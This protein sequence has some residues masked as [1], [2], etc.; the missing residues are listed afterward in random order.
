M[1]YCMDWRGVN[2]DWNR[3]RA[4][5]VTAE[6]G[7]LSAAAR[8]LRMTQPTLGRQVAA[9]EQELGVTLFERVGRGLTLTES[10]LHLVE[11]V[12]AM[13]EAAS[14][15]S[16]S[17]SG[18]AQSVQGQVAIT[19]PELYSSWLLPRVLER[20]RQEAPGITVDLVAT[21]AVRDL[22]RREADIAIRNARPDQPDLIARQ[23]AEDCGS[24][25]ASPAYLDGLGPMRDLSDLAR[26]D[27]IGFDH[28]AQ[29]RTMLNAIGI[30]V[31]EA[32]FPLICESHLVHWQMAREG[33]GIGAG[34]VGMG[35]ADPMVR[36]VFPDRPDFRYP[37]WLVAH[38]ELLTSRRVRLV[39]DVLAEMLPALLR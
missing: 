30:P 19:A 22:K 31:T 25:Y 8:A 37:V 39:Y 26:A 29:Y 21:N 32:N 24:L 36:R 27:F 9:L 16:L 35:E 7:S 17:A 33:L 5:L 23:V 3:A 11:H 34:P 1:H 12:R 13:G 2:F 20:L 15:I 10:G 18:Q 14:R 38:R 28:T 4:F 6:E